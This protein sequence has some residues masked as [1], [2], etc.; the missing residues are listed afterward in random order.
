MPGIPHDPELKTVTRYAP[1]PTGPQHIGGIRTALYCWLFAKKHQGEFILR[2]E[3]TDQSRFTEGAEE[4]IIGALQWLGMDFT[5]GVHIGGKH[6]PYRQSERTEIYRKHA[7]QLVESEQAYYAFDTPVETEA[8]KK[9]LQADGNQKP[10]YDYASRMSMRN[11]L[12]MTPAEL[13]TALENN[14]AHVIRMKVP[15]GTDIRFQDE[16]RGQVT[17]HSSHVDDKVLLKSDGFPT[18][19]LANVVDDFLMGVTNVIRGE[20]WLSSTPLHVLL[21]QAFGWEQSMPIFAH[22]PLLLNP[23]GSKM[24]K[25]NA[26]KFGIPILP[27]KWKWKKDGDEY[28]AGDTWEG[29]REAGY[30]PD[31]LLNCLVLLGWSPDDGKEIMSREELV[32]KFS[33]DRIH[34]AG[35][36]FDIA[37]LKNFNEHYLREMDHA[38]FV[39]ALEGELES[40]G[41]SNVANLNLSR[42]A[43]VMKER[44]TFI[45]DIP[46]QASYFFGKP[47]QWDENMYRKKWNREAIDDLCG[48]IRELKD[49]QKWNPESLESTAMNYMET[50]NSGLGKLMAPLRLALTGSGNGPGVF[51]ILE[52]LGKN[53]SLERIGLAIQKD[54][55]P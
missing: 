20:E 55:A 29:F 51:D 28:K 12:T 24:S 32:S 4:F 47:A 36:R 21:Y 33:L 2:I 17:I 41:F 54:P 3:D 25:R 50:R 31:A 34:K 16:I 49:Q 10:Q 43:E 35:A 53:E 9:R 13:Q 40:S 27:M 48:F 26:D 15:A 46:Q 11:S 6:A 44:I 37:K 5:Q 7:L 30:L 39:S 38:E 42:I 19:H 8:M 1:S 23:D 45:R 22:L 14:E 52:I 18:Y